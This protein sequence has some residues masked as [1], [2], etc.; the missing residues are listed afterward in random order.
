M[1]N[2]SKERSSVV[3]RV[4]RSLAIGV[5]VGSLFGVLLLLA[6]AAVMASVGTSAAV[7]PVVLAVIV[8]ASLVGG[9]T[10]ARSFKERG[11]LIGAACGALLFALTVLGGLGIESTVSG[12]VALLKPILA[13]GGGALGGVSGVNIKRN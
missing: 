2:R 8:L 3:S 6:A 1:M 12:A 4:V 9:F 13:V 10:A 11:L 5:A 7:T